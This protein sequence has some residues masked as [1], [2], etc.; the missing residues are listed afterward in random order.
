MT[1]LSSTHRDKTIDILKGL[2]ICLM[3]TGHCGFLFTH[4]IYLFHMPI[5]FIASGYVFKMSYTE[6]WQG[7]KQVVKKR[8]IG[9]LVPYFVFS[10]LYI[11]VWNP[12]SQLHIT[13]TSP[14]TP[15]DTLLSIVKVFCFKS[16]G[17]PLAGALWF[18]RALFFTTFGF[19]LVEYVFNRIH[20]NF[21]ELFHLLLALILFAIGYLAPN[22]LHGIDL[23]LC[24]YILFFFGSIIRRH[25]LLKVTSNRANI[26]ILTISTLVLYI[27]N[28]LG[29]IELSQRIYTSPWF[30]F[31]AS[32][33]GWYLMYSLSFLLTQTTYLQRIFT[34]L[35]RNT[36]CIIVLHFLCFKVITLL[37]IIIYDLP[38]SKLSA[39]PFLDTQ[40]YWWIPYTIAGICIPL[41]F[42]LFYQKSKTLISLTLLRI[43]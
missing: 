32:L 40:P 11:I 30:F 26:L 7:V 38:I 12:F 10:I 31:V 14:K 37:Q 3:V 39:F 28:G 2:G 9:L 8:V 34:Y 6:S 36:I 21:K 19:A 24:T 1:T 20:L 4:F 33:V 27:L 23:I 42:N 35:G 18:L 13:D 25:Q 22:R 16:E 15:A 5:F 29:S 17:G 41:L 43:K